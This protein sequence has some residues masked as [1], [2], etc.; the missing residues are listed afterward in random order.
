M[1]RGSSES[2]GSGLQLVSASCAK[3]SY[4]KSL[5]SFHEISSPV[6]LITNVVLTPGQAFRASSTLAFNGTFFPPRTPSSAVI[7]I[8]QSASRILSLRDSGEKPPNT[9]ECIAPI[10]A[11]A[12]IANAVSGIIGIYIHTLEPFL[13][14]SFFKT[15]A[16]LHTSSCKF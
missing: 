9:T 6:L 13:T 7:T 2:I 14:P 4:H 10:L 16:N 5:F 1:K 8:E 15:L 12:S 11:Q 3:S